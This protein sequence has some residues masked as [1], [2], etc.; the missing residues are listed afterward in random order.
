[1]K[2][3]TVAAVLATAPLAVAASAI[4]AHADVLPLGGGVPK[5]GALL[6]G[7]QDGSVSADTANQVASQTVSTL[8]GLPL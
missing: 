4:P 7:G 1:M 8:G 6:G 5:A 3:M 2:K